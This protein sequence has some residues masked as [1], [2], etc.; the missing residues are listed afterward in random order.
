M[1]NYRSKLE[2]MVHH[3]LGDEWAYEPFQIA[4]VTK[5]KYTPDFVQGGLLV[6]VK[7]YF[8]PG[9]TQK[10]KAIRDSLEGTDQELVFFLSSPFKKVRK[11]AM[12]NMG[13]W[14]DKEGIPWFVDGI[15]LKEYADGHI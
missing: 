13:A 11:G 3:L 2:A 6:E 4:Y 1:P 12:L 10:Y 15:D 9:D 14:C 5:H 7:G 8:R